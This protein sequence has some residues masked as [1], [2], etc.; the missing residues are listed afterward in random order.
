MEEIGLIAYNQFM[1]CNREVLMM[2]KILVYGSTCVDI[3]INL[4]HLPATG[5]DLLPAGQSMELGGCACNVAHVLKD[6]G[7]DFTFL[8]PAGTGIYGD[9]V[10]ERLAEHGILSTISVPEKENGCCYCL[11]E[12]SGERTFLSIHGAEYLFRR[13][14]MDDFCMADYDMVY[15]CGLEVEE[16]TGEALTAYLGEHRGPQIF[17]A[18]GPRGIR[19][20]KER[21]DRLLSLSP[22]LHINEREAL[23]LGGEP[24]LEKSVRALN[25]RT[26]NTVIVTLGAQGACCLEQDGSF[27]RVP[28]IQAA[29]ADTIG[30]GDAH[31]GA[32]LSCLQR[33]FDM[34][35]SIAAANRLASAVVEAKGAIL[36]AEQ[37][38]DIF[39][40]V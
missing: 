19:I 2:K 1:R 14:W 24:D 30:A 31:I 15:I 16:P 39:S 10:R 27:Y 21:F 5:E 26:G 37:V 28:G 29:V 17:F 25:R 32:V 11:V 12:A 33:G 18:P 23:E 20:P 38:R 36:P 6:S 8:T 35:H 22:V 4:D 34:K 7:A 9:F 3:I 13:E 40:A